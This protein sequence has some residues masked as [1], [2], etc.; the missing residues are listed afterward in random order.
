MNEECRISFDDTKKRMTVSF[1]FK[2][3]VESMVLPY[4]R[5]RKGELGMSGAY[6]FSYSELKVVAHELAQRFR[7]DPKCDLAWKQQFLLVMDHT[8]KS[9]Y[10]PV[11]N[12]SSLTIAQIKLLRL[13][14]KVF[15]QDLYEKAGTNQKEFREALSMGYCPG[16]DSMFC[17]DDYITIRKGDKIIAK[18]ALPGNDYVEL[19]RFLTQGGD[20]ILTMENIENLKDGVRRMKMEKALAL[21]ER[22]CGKASVGLKLGES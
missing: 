6:K 22:K 4:D 18:V 8:L 5:L 13:D 12:S 10:P 9:L 17:T 21:A 2:G 14:T 19:R 3:N 16:V 1:S 15:M 7:L 11:G 20:R